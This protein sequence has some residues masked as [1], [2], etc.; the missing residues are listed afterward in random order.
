M[1]RK[2]KSVREWQAECIKERKEEEICFMKV[3][4][5]YVYRSFE[6]R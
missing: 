4:G 2:N 6:W 5:M 1:K 3:N